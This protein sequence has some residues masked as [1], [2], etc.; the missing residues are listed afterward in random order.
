[1]DRQDADKANA[2]NGNT[3]PPTIN[4]RKFLSRAGV[5]A[6]LAAAGL[7]VGSGGCNR[8]KGGNVIKLISSLPRT[9]SAQGQTDTIVNGIKMAIDEYGGEVVG[10]KIEYLD[11]DDA[12]AIAG[13]WTAE[14]ETTNAQ[15]TAA[16]PTVAAFIGPYN[17]GAA[18]F[19]MPILNE[20]G[21]LQI[22][23]AATWPGL[24]KPGYAPNEP[25][26]FRPAKKITFCRVVPT[27]D[28]Q[29]L[30]GA[31]FA[32]DVL[33]KKKI[34]LLDDT[35]VYG[36][37]VA[38][39]FAK[40][41]GDVGLE[42]LGRESINEKATDFR[43]LMQKVK[44]KNPDLIYFGGT[45]QTKGGQIAKDLKDSGMTCPLMAPDG[46]YEKAF[47][48][49]AGADNVNG[50]CYITFG[51]LDPTKLT[52]GSGKKFVDGYKAK[53]GN[54][55]EA[56]AIYGYECAK[57]VLEAIK[58]VGKNDRD[59]I[60]ETALATKNFDQ[61]ALGKWSFDANG[62]TSQA[63]F[64]VSKIEGGDFVPEKEYKG[65]ELANLK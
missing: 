4:R 15:K 43:G 10:L 2:Q 48:N 31:V 1:V 60:R 45:T 33:K 58:K 30:V 23:P 63:E 34:F 40:I 28:V 65:E 18:K 24:T 38:D 11:W 29:S 55:P 27:D 22:S 12:T 25:D 46:C 9:G 14:Q 17:S 13:E 61:G 37:G 36:K 20:A 51:G 3:Q 32:R 53:F 64:T 26:Q 19:S 35:Q 41:A 50:R 62:D 44:E 6:G 54:M 5:A 8:N 56:Y 52:S 39:L 59:A 7:Y 42:I 49:S 47:I 57:V 21:V 16:D